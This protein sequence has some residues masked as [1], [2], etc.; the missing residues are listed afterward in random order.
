MKNN[1]YK[2]RKKLKIPQRILA[3]DV[4]IS[5]VYLSNIENGKAKPSVEIAYKI[6]LRLNQTVEEIFFD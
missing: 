3:D 4:G 2:Y 6:A 1:L 5:R